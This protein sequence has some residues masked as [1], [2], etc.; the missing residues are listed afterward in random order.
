MFSNTVTTLAVSL[1]ARLMH[2]AMSAR[3]ASVVPAPTV[4]PG[5]EIV[6]AQSNQ[7]MIESADVLEVV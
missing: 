7:T 5:L 2:S 1:C 4:E 3:D 6:E